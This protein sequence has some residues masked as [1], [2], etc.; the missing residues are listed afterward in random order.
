MMPM[1]AGNRIHRHGTLPP[2]TFTVVMEKPVQTN[3]H[4]VAG[5]A[6]T[7][8]ETITTNVLDFWLVVF[9]AVSE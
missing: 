2:A 4:I 3:V 6:A 9:L 1:A 7:Q 5:I 8:S